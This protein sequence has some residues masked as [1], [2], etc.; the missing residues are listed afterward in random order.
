METNE[1]AGKII[2]LTAITVIAAV[3]IPVILTADIGNTKEWHPIAR[4][5]WE[6]KGVIT[7]VSV[8]LIFLHVLRD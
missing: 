3:F 4:V 5:L 8:L 2:V 7:V 6:L 1:I